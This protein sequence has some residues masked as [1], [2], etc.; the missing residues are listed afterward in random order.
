MFRP[1][2]PLGRPE[3]V[4]LVALLFATIAFSI[5]AMLPSLPLIAEELT[6]ADPNR[7]QLVLAAFIF[8]MG[9]GTLVAGP[10]SD[11]FGRKPVITAGLALYAVGAVM[12][13]VASSLE[14]LL[15]ARLIQGLG[16]AAPRVVAQALI[17][18]LHAGRR[19]AQI[20]S[21]VMMV[22]I[23]VPAVAPSIG[24]LIAAGFGWRGVF[25]AFVV[26]AALCALWL[27]LRQPET[28][29]P[30]NA[31]SLRARALWEAAAEVLGNRMV[32]IYIAVL[33]LGFGQMFAL[34][35]SIQQI[36]GET[37]DRAE[38]F[39]L[40][41]LVGALLSGL[42]TVFNAMLVMRLGMR[43]LTIYAFGAQSVIALAMLGLSLAAAPGEVL[44]FGLFF[45]WQVTLFGIAGLS[46][47]N[48]NAL[49]LEPMG[50]I[51]GMAASV[52]AAISTVLSVAIAAPI[53]LAFD[54][55][56]TPLLIGTLVCSTLALAL[57]IHARRLD[58]EPRTT[59][60][61]QG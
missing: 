53:G 34:L 49:A 35:S 43:R 57:M 21:F 32:R 58:P 14:M 29:T 27:N 25:G 44:P 33:T 40:W 7:A 12:A 16:A 11:T 56:P 50:H 46:F 37:Y 4:A 3:F 9:A 15:A 36:F 24:A 38:S 1:V 48:L 22:F 59:V 5:D 54:G 8:G 23:L 51:A 26:F 18:D 28:L 45:A 42:S 31:R 10:L 41:F 55:T 47:G 19:M 17:R 52:V 39:P 20:S 30:E 13:A 6:P 60:P 61:G 2:T